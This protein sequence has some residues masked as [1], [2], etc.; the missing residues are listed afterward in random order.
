MRLIVRPSARFI[1]SSPC[2]PD[3]RQRKTD[4]EQRTGQISTTLRYYNFGNQAED[5]PSIELAESMGSGKNGKRYQLLIN[6]PA[7]FLL[8]LTG[9]YP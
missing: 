4:G 5:Q 8:G 9:L 6:R 1:C 2:G 3:G 7:A